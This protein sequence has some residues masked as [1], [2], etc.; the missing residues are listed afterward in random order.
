MRQSENAEAQRLL[1]VTMSELLEGRLIERGGGL[2]TSGLLAVSAPELSQQEAQR[3]PQE[4]P[5]ERSVYTTM[6]SDL[7]TCSNGLVS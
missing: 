5:K 3:H 4:P 6:P 7:H 2:R 1:K